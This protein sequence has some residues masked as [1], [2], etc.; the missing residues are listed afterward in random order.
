MKI[1]DIDL[2][3]LRAQKEENFRERLRFIDLYVAWIKRTPNR[4][5]SRQQRALLGK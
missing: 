3:E 5:W 1:P 4:E 2:D